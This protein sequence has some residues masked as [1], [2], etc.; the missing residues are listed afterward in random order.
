MNVGVIFDANL[1]VG[2]S[3]REEAKYN[4]K[5][6]VCSAGVFLL[7]RDHVKILILRGF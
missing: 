5:A 7:Y 2:M 4:K 3:G 6:P 1:S